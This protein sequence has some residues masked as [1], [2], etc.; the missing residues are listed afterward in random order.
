MIVLQWPKMGNGIFILSMARPYHGF[1]NWGGSRT[2]TRAIR[3][4]IPPQSSNISGTLQSCRSWCDAY[5][6]PNGD[7][8]FRDTSTSELSYHIRPTAFVKVEIELEGRAVF[9]NR[10]S[11]KHRRLS[12]SANQ[13]PLTHEPGCPL[14][15]QAP[16]LSSSDNPIM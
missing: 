7:A 2:T 11:N 12:S 16:S 6:P 13:L 15:A 14:S 8:P 3:K 4:A 5:L 10:P 9:S 1:A